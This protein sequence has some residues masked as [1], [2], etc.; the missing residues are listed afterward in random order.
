[1]A[2]GSQ[3]IINKELKICIFIILIA[4]IIIIFLETKARITMQKEPTLSFSTL[5]HQDIDPE[6]QIN[7]RLINNTKEKGS[8]K[9]KLIT[10][11]KDGVFYPLNNTKDF[12]M[13]E[14]FIK[15]NHQ[16][17]YIAGENIYFSEDNSSI[18]ANS[19][20]KGIIFINPTIA[21][22]SITLEYHQY[23]EEKQTQYSKRLK[24]SD[25]YKYNSRM[26]NQQ[27]TLDDFDQVN[28]LK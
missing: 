8:S 12:S 24:L 7:I 17:A 21:D 5:A 18:R 20:R 10:L 6:I 28:I 3:I 11:L 16:F 26:F 4:I 22:D 19:D 13:Y 27:T 1:M 9:N 23:Y 15:R 25:S 2:G 14:I